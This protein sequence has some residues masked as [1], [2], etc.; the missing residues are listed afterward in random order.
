MAGLIR[1]ITFSCLSRLFSLF[2]SGFTMSCILPCTSIR[3]SVAWDD[4][5]EADFEM[6]HLSENGGKTIDGIIG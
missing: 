5:E 6:G 2:V 1:S 4:N 3:F